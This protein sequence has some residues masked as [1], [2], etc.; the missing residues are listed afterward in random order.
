[1]RLTIECESGYNPTIQS[2]HFSRG[3]QEQSFGLAQINLPSHPG[4][5]QEQ[6][7]NPDF[8]LNFMAYN[9][10]VGKKAMWMCYTQLRNSGKIR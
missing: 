10:S 1:M 8:A 2:Q 3:E 9:F 5:T 4:I 7:I 6:A